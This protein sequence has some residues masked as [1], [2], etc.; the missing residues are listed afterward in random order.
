MKA[1][2]IGLDGAT[3]DIIEPLVEAGRLPHLATLMARGVYGPLESTLPPVSG[4]AWVSFMTGKQPGRH[5]ILGFTQHDLSRY[6]GFSQTVVRSDMYAGQ[7]LFDILSERG[8]RV[9]AYRVP[10]T[11]PVWP[12]NGEM[13]A[14]HPTPDRRRAF[15]YP[16]YLA[17]RIGPIMLLSNDEIRGA[18]VEDELRDA[19]FQ[20]DVMIR[21]MRQAI[22]SGRFDLVMGVTGISD[23]FQHKFWKYYDP[24][25]PC[26]T[27]EE[28]KR[29]GTAIEQGYAMLDEMVG[30][31]AADLD[32]EWFIYIISDHGGGPRPPWQFNTN[33]WLH[34]QGWLRLVAG[35]GGR[36]TTYKLVKRVTDRFS[37]PFRQWVKRRLPERLRKQVTQM[38]QYGGLIDWH[39]TRAYRVPLYSFVEG[40]HLNVVGRQPA[41]CVQPGAEYER[42]REEIIAA[43]QEVR[44]PRTGEPIVERAWPREAL[45]AGP[46]LDRIPDI[47]FQM[48]SQ[49]AGGGEMDGLVSPTPRSYLEHFSGDHTLEGI[50]ILA[51]PSVCS[52]MRLTHARLIDVVPT[53]LYS[54]N[55]PIPEDMDGRVLLEAFVPDHVADHPVEYAAPVGPDLSEATDDQGLSPEEEAGILETLRELGYVE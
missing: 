50:F 34:Q 30:A 31:L 41:G 28:G 12:I 24:S 26:Y 45:Y 20:T 43:L 36:R 40:I 46:Y 13:V 32:E 33:A 15:T 16:A 17:D 14:G 8:L 5:G 53:V 1:L 37:N 47:V 38:R 35:A 27:A 52:G 55:Q 51:G 44:D 11:Y 39:Q 54:L 23:G 6:D 4:A 21:Y 2:I 25:H 18:G 3:F 48:R 22:R 29:W 49:Y 7:T 10:M 42:L 9:S 19:R